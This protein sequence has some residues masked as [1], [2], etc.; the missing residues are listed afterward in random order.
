MPLKTASLRKPLFFINVLQYPGCSNN[1]IFRNSNRYVEIS[2]FAVKF[3]LVQ[4]G[5]RMPTIFIIH[6]RLRIPL[7]YLKG[8]SVI[9]SAR[10]IKWKFFMERSSNRYFLEGRKWFWQNQFNDVNVLWMVLSF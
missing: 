2:K 1:I 9:T 10:E 4:I 8:L 7:C 6:G 3:T 5:H